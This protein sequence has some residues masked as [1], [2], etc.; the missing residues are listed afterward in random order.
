MIPNSCVSVCRGCRYRD[1]TYPESIQ[2][3]SDQNERTLFSFKGALGSI[4]QSDGGPWGLRERVLLHV[5]PGYRVGL[6]LEDEV[7]EIPDC[8]AQHPEVNSIIQSWKLSFPSG[9]PVRYIHLNYSLLTIVVKATKAEAPLKELHLWAEDFLLNHPKRLQGVFLNFHPASGDRVFSEKNWYLLAGTEQGIETRFRDIGDFTYGPGSFL[10]NHLTLYS[11][12]LENAENY[13]KL[14]ASPELLFDFY[15]GIGL[16]TRRFSRDHFKKVIG[17]EL[18]SRSLRFAHVNSGMSDGSHELLQGKVEER[19][20]QIDEILKKY[21]TP[22]GLFLNPSRIG[23]GTKVIQWII[24]NRTRIGGIAYLSCSA[25]TL[26]RDLMELDRT[27]FKVDEIT[28][29]DFFPMTAHLE[30]LA[31]IRRAY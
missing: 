21:S 17:V 28:P 8:P 20:P 5:E 27:G 13:L 24:E 3:K 23:L 19:L 25:H 26:A 6:I 1:L 16:S 18:S 2:K 14:H 10:Q 30:N 31:F 7:L 22:V 29:Y 12:A 9:L 4:I 15:C 11:Q